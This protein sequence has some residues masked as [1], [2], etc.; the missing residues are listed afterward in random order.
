[1]RKIND[2]K[3]ISKEDLIQLHQMLEIIRSNF[4]DEDFYLNMPIVE[5]ALQAETLNPQQYG[6]I[7]QKKFCY[8]NAYKIVAQAEDK[9][10]FING[11]NEYCEFKC[12]YI[13]NFSRYINIKHIR[14]WQDLD[15]GF[16]VFTINTEDRSD[17]F[18]KLYKLSKEQ[19]QMECELN[20]ATPCNM[21]KDNSSQNMKVELGFSIEVG[22]EAYQRWEEKY[23]RKGFDIKALSDKRIEQLQAYYEREQLYKD[24]EARNQEME[25]KLVSQ[26]EKWTNPIELVFFSI[27]NHVPLTQQQSRT[28]AYM[29]HTKLVDRDTFMTHY[30][31]ENL[32]DHEKRLLDLFERADNR[33]TRKGLINISDIKGISGYI[34][35]DY[36]GEIAKRR[37]QTRKAPEYEDGYLIKH[38]KKYKLVSIATWYH[39]SMAGF[40]KELSYTSHN[41]D[42]KL[43]LIDKALYKKHGDLNFEQAMQLKKLIDSRRNIKSVPSTI[44]KIS[45]PNKIRNFKQSIVKTADYL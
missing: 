19:M 23:L 8:L 36:G 33:K 16:Y 37:P 7:I 31:I 3:I 2:L 11:D 17:P 38:N 13:N 25:R 45:D 43:Y 18:F 30:T 5:F 40:K 15:G 9:G 4:E 27:E 29:Y 44:E 34:Q 20:N 1:M 35:K 10:D 22:S 41:L 14:L 12:S 26:E 42:E 24:I 6:I 21:T 28:L 32:Y 39:Y